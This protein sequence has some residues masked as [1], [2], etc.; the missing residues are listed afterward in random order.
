MHSPCKHTQDEDQKARYFHFRK[1]RSEL[2][3]QLIYSVDL[4][5]LAQ[6]MDSSTLDKVGKEIAFV[7]M[8]A[9]LL[10]REKCALLCVCVC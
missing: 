8:C 1:Q 3:W 5:E 9:D 4:D 7:C 2:Q 10:G 6:R